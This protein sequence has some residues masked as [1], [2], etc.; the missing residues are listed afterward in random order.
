MV[1]DLFQSGVHN[2][3]SPFVG[4][5][6]V[7][8]AQTGAHNRQRIHHAVQARVGKK[9]C[10]CRV[11]VLLHDFQAGKRVAISF[12]VGSRAMND[13]VVQAAF[14][15]HFKNV[16]AVQSLPQFRR[17]AGKHDFAACSHVFFLVV[18]KNKRT[19]KHCDKVRVVAEVVKTGDKLFVRYFPS[20]AG[21]LCLPL[22]VLVSLFRFPVGN[23]ETPQRLPGGFKLQP[24]VVRA[25]AA[26][27][28]VRLAVQKFP[29]QT[30]MV[31]Q[32]DGLRSGNFRRFRFLS[33]SAG[34]ILHFVNPKGMFA[35]HCFYPYDLR[36]MITDGAGFVGNIVQ[37]PIPEKP[38]K[39]IER[40]AAV[41]R[42]IGAPRTDCGKAS[43]FW[44]MRSLKP[45]ISTMARVK[46]AALARP[47]QT[48]SDSEKPFC[49]ERMA[50]PKTAQLVVISGR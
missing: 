21:L 46:P 43:W 35:Y 8:A 1:F 42:A 6:F 38:M 50:T 39:A 23:T 30:I 49:M 4:A 29:F 27:F 28:V 9:V 10:N 2:I 15:A 44:L 7:A 19:V 47:K 26:K 31:N 22:K 25:E 20:A 45:A 34:K 32:A 41:M 14:F 5:L 3:R 12:V 13:F 37:L 48:E 33:E 40:R 16:D 36:K 18:K 17:N 24:F 11:G